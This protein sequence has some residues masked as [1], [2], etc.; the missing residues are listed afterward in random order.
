MSRVQ[1]WSPQQ[2]TRSTET[3]HSRSISSSSKTRFTTWKSVNSTVK[4]PLSMRIRTVSTRLLIGFSTSNAAVMPTTLVKREGLETL[5]IDLQRTCIEKTVHITL[6]SPGSWTAKL[7]S[8]A[9]GYSST[10]A[11]PH[12]R[13]PRRS[14]CASRALLFSR[15][16]SRRVRKKSRFSGS[17]TRTASVTSR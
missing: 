11:L 17:R 13:L 8:V 5:S 16:T 12:T 15:L 14:L 6:S 10:A 2:R 1:V 9:R 4:S 7:T 3:K